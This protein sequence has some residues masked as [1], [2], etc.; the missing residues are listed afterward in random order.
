MKSPWGKLE[1]RA[2]RSLRADDGQTFR[3]PVREGSTTRS[4]LDVS[5]Q[6]MKGED[7]VCQVQL[8]S[9]S[10][11]YG[12]KRVDSNVFGVCFFAGCDAARFTRLSHKA[13]ADDRAV[14]RWRRR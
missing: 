2:C 6:R 8:S 9:I 3:N 5:A 10:F 4:E 7:S 1:G 12:E 11:L 13:R 14:R